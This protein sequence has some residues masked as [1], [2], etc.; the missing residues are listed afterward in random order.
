[1]VTKTRL[2]KKA[3]LGVITKT[4]FEFFYE[5]ITLNYFINN[6]FLNSF[7]RTIDGCEIYDIV[8]KK[9]TL[10]KNISN[11]FCSLNPINRLFLK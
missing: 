4:V 7:I 9:F 2:Y 10:M 5:N 3:F 6:I 1:M 11:F 8:S